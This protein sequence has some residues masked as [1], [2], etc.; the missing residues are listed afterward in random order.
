[1]RFRA[2]AGEVETVIALEWIVVAPRQANL[3]A[4]RI[5]D[6]LRFDVAGHA[7]DALDD[8]LAASGVA[9]GGRWIPHTMRRLAEEIRDDR[10]NLG[11]LKLDVLRALRCRDDC[12]IDHVSLIE[13]RRHARRRAEVVRLGD[14]AECP[15]RRRL[16]GDAV[17]IGTGPA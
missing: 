13:K 3:P 2:D 4:L 11:I 15:L 16:L 12:R 8:L 7:A 6:L 9:P 10:V 14:P 1:M 5:F 17:Q